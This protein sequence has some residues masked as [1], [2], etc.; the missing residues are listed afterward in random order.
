[1]WYYEQNG[2]RIG[3]VDEDTMRQLIAARTISIDT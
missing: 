1:M 3:P 2:N